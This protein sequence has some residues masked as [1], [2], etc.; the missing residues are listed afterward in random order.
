WGVRKRTTA[1]GIRS[2][3]AVASTNVCSAALSIGLSA[4][5]C[6][7][8]HDENRVTVPSVTAVIRAMVT[9]LSFVFMLE[10]NYSA[11]LIT[12]RCSQPEN[13]ENK[14]KDSRCLIDIAV[15]ANHPRRN[16]RPAPLERLGPRLPRHRRIL[17]PKIGCL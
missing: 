11:I 5:T 17:R 13:E 4:D 7:L 6:C 12:P 9:T 1:P 8:W 2:S 14:G 3:L 10:L 16:S 15:A